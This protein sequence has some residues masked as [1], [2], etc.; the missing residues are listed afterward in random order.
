MSDLGAVPPV[1]GPRDPS[2][3]A[4]RMGQHDVPAGRRDVG[5][6]P[7][8][9]DVRA[10]DRQGAPMASDARAVAARCRSRGRSQRA[11]PGCG[12]P[13]PWSI[14]GWLEGEPAAIVG[15]HD[16]DRLADDLAA[17]LVALRRRVD[18]GRATR[19]DATAST[20]AGPCRPGTNRHA[21]R[22]TNSANRSTPPARSRSGRRRST[23]AWAGPNVWVHGDMTGSNL[24]IGDD[25]L[26]GVIDFGCFGGRRSGMRSHGRHGRC[27]RGPAGNDSS[28]PSRTT[29]TRGRGRGAGR[30]GRR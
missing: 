23:A 12:F 3:R 19:P 28:R 22:S 27:S 6:T 25:R 26:C 29:T 9:Q 8:P 2:R 11:E 7:E 20:A 5:P 1:G 24:L 13:S 18:R 10:P 30:S 14:Y 15:V 21:P 4:R 17:F 16:H